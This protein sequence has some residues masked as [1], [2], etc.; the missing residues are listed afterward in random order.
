[1][2]HRFNKLAASSP[3]EF[4]YVIIGAGSAG[5][6]IAYRLGE[7]KSISIAL[8]EYGG[9]DAG[10][11]IQ[12][13][14][15]LSYPM[16][17]R[18]YDW[19]YRAVAEPALN[20]RSLVCPRGKVIGGSSSINGMIYV[21]G[22]AGDYDHW[23]AQGASGWSYADILPY[24]KKMETALN[25]E[26]GWRGR[27]GP[28][29]ITRSQQSNPLHH[30]FMRAARQAGYALT[31]DYN[32]QRQEGFGPADMTVYKG[33]RWSTANAYL[34]PALKR[35][36]LHLFTRMLV[37]KIL[38]S[39]KRSI[40]V[41]TL[42]RGKIKNILA[43]KGVILSAGAIA[44]PAILQ[45]SGIGPA[46]LLKKHGIEIIAD[47]PGVGANLQEHLEVYFQI[48]CRQPVS[49]YKYLNPFSKAL[50]GLRWILF[51]DGIG[52][53]NQFETVGFIRSD[54]GVAYPD[55][56]FHF[57]PVAIRYDGKSAAD[58]H[59]FQLH[60]GP[61]R[62]GSRGYVHITSAD[63]RAAPE[64]RFNYLSHPDDLPDFRKA[65]HLTREILSQEALAPYYDYEIQPGADALSDAALDAFVRAEA[66]SAYHPC[67]TCK[68][69]SI[70]D[71]MAVVSPDCR[72]IETENLYCAD[73]AIFPRI[74][75]GNL[76]A[77]SI[78]TGEKAADHI[79]GKA[80][81]P[82]ANE[83]PFFSP[84]WQTDQR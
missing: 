30:A 62:S 28:L 35:G 18:F 72:V 20:G 75:N 82:R 17:M 66:E 13:P 43:R 7:D 65:L 59:G 41:Q 80:V 70:T 47:R 48:A 84:D 68:M 44:S 79:K 16:N 23:Q 29:H 46:G 58:G 77:P 60:V 76:N 33:R 40:G 53:S 32:G 10:P 83:K 61:M 19:G 63:A 57:L 15:A 34:R 12:M 5:S 4:D 14:A 71:P 51:K 27:D 52:A 50:I 73:S 31:P 2:Q 49:L 54:K 69:G 26:A 81:L 6:A 25:G 37:D 74:T 67:G 24:F 8:I 45:R 11:F 64:I 36:N 22:H 42:H 3:A 56:Q 78:M 39:G 38:F 21:R 9:S 55:I 1:M